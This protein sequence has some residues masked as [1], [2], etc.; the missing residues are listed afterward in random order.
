MR[1]YLVEVEDPVTDDSLRTAIANQH[2]MIV[3]EVSV[4]EAI[5]AD[6]A[7]APIRRARVQVEAA[8]RLIE[9]E[10][11]GHDFQGDDL[12]AAHALLELAERELEDPGL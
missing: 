11:A 3:G 10:G 8:R 4:R 5:S 7:D 12:K 1:K 6:L 9:Y 2:T